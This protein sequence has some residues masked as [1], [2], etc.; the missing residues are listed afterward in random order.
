[1]IFIMTAAT[2]AA[3][4]D[5]SSPVRTIYAGTAESVGIAAARARARSAIAAMMAFVLFLFED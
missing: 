1:M 2:A 5:L 3:D 4:L